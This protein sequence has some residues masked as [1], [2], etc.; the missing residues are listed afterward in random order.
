MKA[1]IQT[2]EVTDFSLFGDLAPFGGPC[3]RMDLTLGHGSVGGAVALLKSYTG[4]VGWRLTGR[5]AGAL[6]RAGF[7][8]LSWR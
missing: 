1:D 7:A 8:C 3:V 4:C 6:A 2:G 5:Q